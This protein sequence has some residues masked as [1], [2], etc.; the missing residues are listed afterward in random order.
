MMF[1][2][3]KNKIRNKNELACTSIYL[4]SVMLLVFFW[5]CSKNNI[6]VK[7]IKIA[8][9]STMIFVA[10]KAAEKFMEIH[11]DIKITISPGGSGVGVKSVGNG[12][13]DIGMVSRNISEEERSHFPKVLFKEFLIGKD[14]VACVVSSE[15][16]E[17]GLEA[18]SKKQLR[19]IYSGEI[20]NWREVGGPDKEILCIDKE[21]HRG[22][23][24]VFMAYVFDDE[25]AQA[26]GADLIVGSNNETQTKVALSDTAI[27]MV[28]YAWINAD[29]KGL[30][31]K[32]GK[33]I[34]R[35]SI[36]NIMNGTYPISR[37]LSLVTNGMPVGKVNDYINFIFSS[38][39]QKIVEEFGFVPI[40]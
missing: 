9:S 8:G 23:R 28:S 13:V 20:T 21:S 22:A 18:L 1:S 27:A 32:V 11:P 17:T 7:T 29:V 6:P 19:Q 16:Y 40:R 4:L 39:G 26:L 25:K 36:E 38:E 24:R 33:K 30:G 2:Y 34:I 3:L 37:N 10:T 35:P 14:A 15:I 31:I 12:L 5:G